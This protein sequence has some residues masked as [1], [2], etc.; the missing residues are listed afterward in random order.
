MDTMLWRLSPLYRVLYVDSCERG[1]I[2]SCQN[3]SSPVIFNRFRL[4]LE[5]EFKPALKIVG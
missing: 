1:R 5:L 4:N 3:I 2:N